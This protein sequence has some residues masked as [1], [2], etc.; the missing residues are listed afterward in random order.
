[1]IT[2]G[3]RFAGN[4]EYTW[5]F[6]HRVLQRRPYIKLEWCEKAL[7]DYEHMEVQEDGFLRYWIYLPEVERYLRVV[8]TPD[9]RIHNAF[10]DRDYPD[11]IL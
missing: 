4:M 9:G 5:Y 11:N 3:K 8:T 7:E 6:K 10:Y 2:E 1:M